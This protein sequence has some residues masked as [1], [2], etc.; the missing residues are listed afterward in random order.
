VLNDIWKVKLKLNKLLPD[1]VT[2]VYDLSTP[3]TGAGELPQVKGSLGYIDDPVF[4]FFFFF[5][6]F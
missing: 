4:L 3:G 2:D 5:F 1:M 6:F